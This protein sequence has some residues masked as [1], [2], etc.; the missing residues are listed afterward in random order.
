VID[1]GRACA[2]H[3]PVLVDF[4]DRAEVRPETAAALRH[5]DECARCTDAVE[6]TLLAITALRRLADDVELAEPRTDA[7]PRLRAR[8]TGLRRRPAVMSP[9]A[10][11]AMSFAIVGVL[12]LPFR[13]GADRFDEPTAPPA[14][15]DARAVTAERIIESAYVASS[16]RLAPAPPDDAASSSASSGRVTSNIPAEIWQVRKE[17]HS[18]KPTGRP[19]EPI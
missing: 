14:A 17:V 4:V 18:A 5:L 6:S 9:L 15:P 7:W 11:V 10:G 2:R 16:R 1:F 12:V 19:A 13:L 8:I 3:R